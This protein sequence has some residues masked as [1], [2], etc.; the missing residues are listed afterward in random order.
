MSPNIGTEKVDAVVADNTPSKKHSTLPVDEKIAKEPKKPRI[1]GKNSTH[2]CL[3]Q[4]C[5]AHQ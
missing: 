1:I 3:V 5:F 2:P 4:T